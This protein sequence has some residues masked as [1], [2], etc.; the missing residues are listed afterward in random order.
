MSETTGEH[1]GKAVRDPETYRSALDAWM[2]R[3]HPH[4]R[5]LRVHSVDMPTATGFSNET[6]FFSA[7]WDEG[8]ERTARYVA[9]IE[10]EDGGI[11]PVQTPACEVSVAVQHRIMEVVRSAGVAPVPPTLPYEGD[12]SVLGR[13]FF[14]MEFV[15]GEIPADVPRYSQAGFVAEEASPAER[16]R[17]VRNGIETMAALHTL[18][19]RQAGLDWLDP[20][21]AGRPGLEHQLAHYRSYVSHELSGREHPVMMQCLDWLGAN[22]PAAAA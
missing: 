5:D 6:V 3:T 15:P 22:A 19:W 8:G 21:G 2:T 17:M 1:P 14:V 16:E 12:R 18:D 20:S 10:P 9:R 13:P 4:R 11:F 7:S